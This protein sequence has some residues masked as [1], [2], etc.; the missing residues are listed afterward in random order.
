MRRYLKQ[1]T[2]RAILTGKFASDFGAELMFIGGDI[3]GN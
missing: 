2:R 3:A 1:M